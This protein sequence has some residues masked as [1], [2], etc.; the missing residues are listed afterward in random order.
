[1]SITSKSP[2]DVLLSAW[3]VALQSLRAYSHRFSPKKFTQHQ[4]FACVVLKEVMKLDYRG[5]TAL[6]ADSPELAKSICLRVVPHFTTLQ[7]ASR[8]L[9]RCRRANRLLDETIE[10]ARKAKLIGRRIEIGAIDGSGFEAHH[11]SRYFVKRC[12]RGGKY[13]Y[14]NHRLTYRRF[15]KRG[16]RGVRPWFLLLPAI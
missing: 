12:E 4:L 14:K 1:M 9:L 3:C 2:K 5:I 16:L 15:P 8:R 11:V 13:R 6:L 10:L 7:K